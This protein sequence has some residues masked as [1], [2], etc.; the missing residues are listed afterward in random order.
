[1]DPQVVARPLHQSANIYGARVFLLVWAFISAWE[2]RRAP[3]KLVTALARIRRLLERAS[4]AGFSGVYEALS[5][6]LAADRLLGLGNLPIAGGAV[7][8]RGS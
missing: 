4:A 8:C 2:F 7:S 3:A 6:G 5:S 1:M